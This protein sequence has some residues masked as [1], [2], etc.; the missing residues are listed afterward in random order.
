[1]KKKLIALLCVFSSIAQAEL[2]SDNN[3]NKVDQIN[4]EILLEGAPVEA[5]KSLLNNKQKLKEQLEQLYIK[6]VVAKLAIE[7][8]LDT[9]GMNAERLQALMNNALYLLKLDKLRKSNKKDYS[10]FAKQLYLVKQSDYTLV[11]RIDAAHIL[12]STKE[13]ADAEALNKAQ[14]IR[15]QLLLGANFSKLAL[16]ESDDN[17]VRSNQGELGTFTVDKMVKPFSDAALALQIGE[18]SEPVK[19]RYGYHIIKL[20]NKIAAGVRP[21]DEV[22]DRIVNKLKKKDWQRIKSRFFEQLKKENEMQMDESAIDEFVIK[23]LAELNKPE[24]KLQN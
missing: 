12:I 15:Q 8:G 17:S 22:K 14:K 1:M 5:Q 11:E 18:I 13:L 6:E 10:K 21:F 3:A 4:L 24:I 9:E 23:K 19:T 7:E 2:V 20:N 16:K